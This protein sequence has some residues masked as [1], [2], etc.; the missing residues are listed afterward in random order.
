MG[1]VLVVVAAVVAEMVASGGGKTHQ[2]PKFIP[3]ISPEHPQLKVLV[4]IESVE[5][6]GVFR[7]GDG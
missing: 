7:I 3:S 4:M 1:L 5:I 2:P 6:D